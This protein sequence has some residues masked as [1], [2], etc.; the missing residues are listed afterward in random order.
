MGQEEEN[1]RFLGIKKEG[2]GGV[3]GGGREVFTEPS[4]AL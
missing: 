4:D 1:G 3:V 2:G